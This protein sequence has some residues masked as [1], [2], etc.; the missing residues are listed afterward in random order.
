M[1]G[2]ILESYV[3]WIAF[4]ILFKVLTFIIHPLIGLLFGGEYLDTLRH[5]PFSIH[6]LVVSDLENI[7]GT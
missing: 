2:V 1:E 7:A 4:I 3:N 6:L 5:D